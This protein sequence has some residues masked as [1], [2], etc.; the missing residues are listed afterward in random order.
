MNCTNCGAPVGEGV[1][2]CLSCGSPVAPAPPQAAQTPSG[3]YGPAPAHAPMGEQS[4]ILIIPAI[5]GIIGGI[6][7]IVGDFGGWYNYNYYA[8]YEEWIYVNS[9]GYAAV[10]ILPMALLLF[11][12]AAVSLKAFKSPP[13]VARK[14]VQR[15]LIAALVVLIITVIGAVALLAATMDASD[16]WLGVG[17]YGAFFGSLISFIVLAYERKRL[18]RVLGGP[19]APYQ[20]PQYQP[21]GQPAQPPQPAPYQQSPQPAPPPRPQ[22]PAQPQCR[23]CRALLQP[24][25]KFCHICGAP[26][27]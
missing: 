15:G 1:K 3:P 24:G 10:L 4:P 11:F 8:G 14:L 19:M 21:Y 7:M 18:G 13:P 20:P 5:F 16:N 23:N 17:F 25:V 26:Q 6:M 22:P 2:F 12:S 9:F 27:S